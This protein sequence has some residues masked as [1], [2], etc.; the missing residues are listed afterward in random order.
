[1]GGYGSGRY[2][3]GL[4]KATVEDCHSLDTNDFAK[5]GYFKPGIHYGRARWTRCGNEVGSYGFSVNINDFFALMNFYYNYN[6]KKHPDTKVNLSWYTPGF[7]G[8]RYFFLCPHCG[9]R[10][11]TLHIRGGEIA[12]RICHKL[13]YES[14][15]QNHQFDSLYKHLALDLNTSWQDVKQCMN[16]MMR[17]EG[18]EPK[19]PRGRPKKY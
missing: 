10:M 9:R 19:R 12:C 1:M 16:N 11:R 13:T 4:T 2:Y 14:C 15:N 6:G 3:R 18:K 5:W 17:N 7:G 8:R